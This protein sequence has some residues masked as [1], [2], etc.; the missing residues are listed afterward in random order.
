[1]EKNKILKILIEMGK[2]A[3]ELL[4]ETK[5]GKEELGFNYYGDRSIKMDIIIEKM[6]KKEARE[7]SIAIITEEQPEELP[8][9]NGTFILDPLDGS[10][11][12]VRNFPAYAFAIAWADKENPH[13]NDVQ[14]ALV[15]NLVTDNFYYA[16]KGEGIYINGKKVRIKRK[17]QEPPL[18]G[19]D[20]GKS[21]LTVK[22]IAAR[23]SDFTY[24][25]ML[26]ASTLDMTNVVMDSADAFIDIRGKLLVTHTAGIFLMKEAGVKITDEKGEV[27]NPGLT[28]DT[29]YTIVAASDEE[30]HSK[31]IKMIK[32]VD[33]KNAKIE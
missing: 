17:K 33:D 30:L 9:S 25:R 7:L 14:V 6:V 13:L 31:I 10:K 11:N 3:K 4:L 21:N 28:Q 32:Q 16:V 27:I 26:G 22:E 29:C 20:F 23:L 18:I 12:Y 5:E 2:H 1:M 8:G 15:Y 24:I 19:M